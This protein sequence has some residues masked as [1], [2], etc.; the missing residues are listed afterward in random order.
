MTAQPSA[1]KASG[2]S[3]LLTSLS[4]EAPSSQPSPKEDFLSVIMQALS[5][6]TSVDGGAA[7]KDKNSPSEATKEQEKNSAK[8]STAPDATVASLLLGLLM[9]PVHIPP[10]LMAHKISVPSAAVVPFDPSGDSTSAR[11][12]TENKSAKP[13]DAEKAEKAPSLEVE[14]LLPKEPPAKNLLPS[15]TSIANTSQRMNSR[16]ESNEIAG[17]IEQKLPPMAVS[18]VSSADTGG[19]PSNGGAKLPLPF[20]WHEA[21]PETLTI[22]DLS[23]KTATLATPIEAT[24]VEAPVSAGSAAPLERLEQMV[25]HEAISL[26]HSGAESLGVMLKLDSNTQLF[27]QLTTHNGLTQASV[28][29]DRGQFAPE[30][31]QWAQLQQSLARQNIELLPMTGGAN[32][33]FEH[34]SKE[35]SRHGAL[36][37]WAAAEAAVIPAQPRQQQPRQQKE[38]TRSRNQWESWA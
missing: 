3:R 18:A 31:S 8:E 10:K 7:E 22:T 13:D 27:L 17:R 11:T 19:S 28:R 4:S 26:R 33:G 36:H 23:T 25:S 29:L 5:A 15:G 21:P 2:V 37:D 14:A 35:R 12:A 30:D 9:P 20:S 38:Q 32:L 1:P 16:S 24:V 34:P 6:Q